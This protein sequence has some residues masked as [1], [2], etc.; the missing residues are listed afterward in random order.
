MAKKTQSNLSR[1]LGSRAFLVSLSTVSSLSASSSNE[2]VTPQCIGDCRGS[3]GLCK[4]SSYSSLN[5]CALAQEDTSGMYERS[6]HSAAR[7]KLDADEPLFSGL[8]ALIAFHISRYLI[9]VLEIMGPGI[10]YRIE[11]FRALIQ[12][13][14]H[15]NLTKR[16]IETLRTWQGSRSSVCSEGLATSHSEEFQ[17]K[18]K[19][20]MKDRGIEEE[21]ETD[22]WG[23]FADFDYIEEKDVVFAVLQHQL[24][25]GSK[26]ELGTL[27]EAAEEDD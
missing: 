16:S 26:W 12:G 18:T 14:Q 24:S 20:V 25:M 3:R 23:H 13:Y 2:N 10:F 9:F 21:E 4:R 1:S 27:D 11:L 15:D 19:L 5:L 6:L 8:L 22:H 17:P 7:I